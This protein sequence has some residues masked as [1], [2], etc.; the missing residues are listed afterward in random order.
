M[1]K[2]FMYLDRKMLI[3]H[4]HEHEQIFTHLLIQYNPTQSLTG[5]FPST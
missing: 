5:V 4:K 2:Y 1:K 3:H